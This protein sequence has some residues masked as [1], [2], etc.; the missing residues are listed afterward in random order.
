MDDDDIRMVEGGSGLGL[1]DEPLPAVGVGQPVRGEKLDG[2][3]AVEVGVLGLVDS[4]HAALAD[5][6]QYAKVENGLPGHRLLPCVGW[7]RGR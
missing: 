3:K 4:A 7:P 1:Q 2:D 6:I 5:L